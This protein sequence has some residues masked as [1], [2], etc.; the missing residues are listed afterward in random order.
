[1]IDFFF[2]FIPNHN[3]IV[4]QIRMQCAIKQTKRFWF[5]VDLI[6]FFFIQP[7]SSFLFHLNMLVSRQKWRF[8]FGRIHMIHITHEHVTHTHTHTATS[9]AYF[10]IGIGQFL[11][12]RTNVVSLK[13]RHC[14]HCILIT[15]RITNVFVVFVLHM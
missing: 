4:Y 6:V 8:S 11:Y 10:I 1:M 3:N 14:M 7:L 13:S 12:H 2:V 15:S 5:G 9:A